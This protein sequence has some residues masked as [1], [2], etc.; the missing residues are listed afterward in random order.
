MLFLDAELEVWQAVRAGLFALLGSKKK[1]FLSHRRSW[2][3]FLPYSRAVNTAYPGLVAQYREGY[4]W[5]RIRC[6][7]SI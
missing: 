5:G 1:G 2:T 6:L 3:G 4:L 7:E